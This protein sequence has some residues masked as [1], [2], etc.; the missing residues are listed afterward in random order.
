MPGDVA[1]SPTPPTVGPWQREGRDYIRRW[2]NGPDAAECRWFSRGRWIVTIW[3]SA[4]NRK[5]REE[6][7]G[8]GASAKFYADVALK[9]RSWIP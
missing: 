2:S 1:V 3:S 5:V 6:R 9:A 8:D 7:P 4:G